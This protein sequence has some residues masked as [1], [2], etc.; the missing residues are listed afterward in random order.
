M[1]TVKEEF[2]ENQSSDKINSNYQISLS[3]N[4]NS[5]MNSKKLRSSTFKPRSSDN[6]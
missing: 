4:R 1:S 3:Q 6:S 2:I 5:N